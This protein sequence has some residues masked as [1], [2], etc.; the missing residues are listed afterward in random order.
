M[1]VAFLQVLRF[2]LLFFWQV[3]DISLSLQEQIGRTSICHSATILSNA[4]MYCGTTKDDFL[5]ANR[6]WMARSSYW[7]KF[8]VV[9]SLGVIHKVCVCVCVCFAPVDFPHR[10]PFV[11]CDGHV[12]SLE[13]GHLSQAKTVL[14][15][16]LPEGSTESVYGK[17]GSLYGLGLIVANHGHSEIDYLSAHLKKA[18]AMADQNAAPTVQ[19]GACLGLGLAAMG[20]HNESELT[21]MDA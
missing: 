14:K 13:Q 2:I 3:Q 16:F 10:T 5:R 8:S 7:A 21:W 9:A 20:T 17:S 4:V 11:V 6:D 1:R 15:N 18:E 12:C 19:H